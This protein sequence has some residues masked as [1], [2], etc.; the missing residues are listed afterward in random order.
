MTERQDPSRAPGGSPVSGASPNRKSPESSSD[1]GGIF[2]WGLEAYRTVTEDDYR[3]LFSS[4]M[5]VLD[6][7]SLLNLYRYHAET[8]AVLLEV[9]ARL[10][11][12]LWIPHQAMREF[13]DGRIFVIDSRSEET[14]HAI[15][16]IDK[17][18]AELEK[19][20]RTWGRRIGLQ[21]AG[22]ENLAKPIK[23]AASRIVGEIGSLGAD[24][25]F[26]E[27]QDT[28]KDPVV[29]SLS[30]ILAQCVGA[31]LSTDDLREVRKE[32]KQRITE[33]RPPGWKDAGKRENAEGDYI[34][35]YQTLQEAKVRGVDV[36]FT[37]GDVKEDWWR[38][39][40]GESKGP[41]PEL[42]HEMHAVAGVRLFMLRPESLLF[43][44]GKLLGI[45][46]SKESVQDVQRVTTRW[47]RLNAVMMDRLWA[48]GG[49]RCTICKELLATMGQMASGAADPEFFVPAQVAHIVPVSKLRSDESDIDP[50]AYDNL[51]LVCSNCHIKIDSSPVYTAEQ[52]RE[53]KKDH[54]AWIASRKLKDEA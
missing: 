24:S 10:K 3:S 11:D 48:N 16:E 46:V 42:V 33:K 44:A 53:I 5:I 35:W 34:I 6:A 43:H 4:G 12:R 22:I 21:E 37:T 50:Y 18:G 31:P 52:L 28:A 40:R 36:L 1:V 15:A 7:N 13:H 9:L 38:R 17:C 29:E 41:L 2:S 30:H 49:G 8:R 27:A 51:I 32:A 26:G 19:Q 39:E 25:T 45:S 47:R 54:E 20:I 14:A 23:E